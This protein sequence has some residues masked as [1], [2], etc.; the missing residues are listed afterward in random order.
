MVTAG[1]FGWN[2]DASLP[3]R[4]RTRRRSSCAL[5]A[6]P[7][8]LRVIVM[9]QSD[10]LS[11]LAAIGVILLGA[12]ACTVAAGFIADRATTWYHVS[13]R[14]GESG[15]FVV[16][17]ALVA[18]VAA[19]VLGLVVTRVVHTTGRGGA[20]RPVIALFGIELVLL[21]GIGGTARLLA[22]VPPTFEGEELMV[23][24]EVS[25]PEAS[26]PT[27]PDGPQLPR[28][29]LGALSGNVR[30]ASED[31][32]L[33]IADARRENNRVIVPGA[34]ALFTAR[35]QRALEV[36]TGNDSTTTGILLPI[37]AK[38]GA[39]QAQWSDW[40]PHARPGSPALPD[41]VRYRYRV[42]KRSAAIRSTTIGD[43]TIA[44]VARS[45]RTEPRLDPPEWIA[46]ADFVIRR[47]GARVQF[48]PDPAL[49]DSL[50]E[51]SSDDS[52][53]VTEVAAVGGP[54]PAL[55]VHIA[56]GGSVGECRLLLPDGAQVQQRSLGRCDGGIAA[57]RLSDTI[58]VPASAALRVGSVDMTTF[59]TPG[60]F[61]AGSAVLDTRTM[62]VR[63]LATSVTSEQGAGMPLS[64]SPDATRF[65]RVVRRDT[66]YVLEE[67]TIA[68]NER[69][70]I[71]VAFAVPPTGRYEDADRAWFRYYFDWISTG[72][73][74]MRVVPRTGVATMPRR[75]F[76][77]REYEEYHLKGVNPGIREAAARKTVE[78]LGADPVPASQAL[79]QFDVK[80]EGT[81]VHFS[82]T[83]DELSVWLDNSRSRS[84][85]ERIARM[86]DA[87]LQQGGLD[88]Y[89][90]GARTTAQ[91]TTPRR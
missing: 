15:Y 9:R 30:R 65:A 17:L 90:I 3:L 8:T 27:L 26:A 55:I 66:T 87:E 49:R 42:V 35:G 86:M 89:L 2:A 11:W 41:G 44:T 19:V 48:T 37:P 84:M 76:M 81:V 79:Y 61:M 4:G 77:V 6:A 29:T 18:F 68:S 31:G 72:G 39:D 88:P 51:P 70:D 22:D 60:L 62:T 57:A 28:V 40:L 71:A 1:G 5:H 85:M 63:P 50:Q 12:V 56:G 58:P 43:F 52:L 7:S 46:D 10:K 83:N 13:S 74:P 82:H 54:T 32:P 23:A 33:W 45:F 34:V 36:H 24:V 14:E 59:A 21:G 47:N 73:T 25:W 64:L 78:L 16:G 53:R 80:L 67:V 20:W 91:S 38:P 69:R 75:G